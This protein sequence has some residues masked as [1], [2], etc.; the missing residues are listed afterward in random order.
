[1]HPNIEPKKGIFHFV[2]NCIDP[3]SIYPYDAPRERK[4]DY[5]K[6]QKQF[7]H[8]NLQVLNQIEDISSKQSQKL[9]EA[10]ASRIVRFS[11][12]SFIAEVSKQNH[13]LAAST[14]IGFIPQ[15][16]NVVGAGLS[17][18]DKFLVKEVLSHQGAITFINN[19]LPSIY[20]EPKELNLENLNRNKTGVSS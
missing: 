15:V 7:T 18:Y 11:S 19:K 16:G 6:E 1:M 13:K 3:L 8:N 12:E 10:V 4:P 2:H 17:F 5:Q 20:Q 9:R 14:A